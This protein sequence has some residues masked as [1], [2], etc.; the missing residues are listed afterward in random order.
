MIVI[1]QGIDYPPD[2]MRMVMM[3]TRMRTNRNKQSKYKLKVRS[4]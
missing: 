1:L 4:Q 2:C 3:M